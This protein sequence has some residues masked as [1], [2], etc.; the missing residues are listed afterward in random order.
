MLK[1]ICT[2]LAVILVAIL[3]TFFTSAPVLAADLRSGDTVTVASGD[4]VDDDLYIAGGSIVIDGTI[5]GDLWAV[6]RDVTVNGTVNGSLVAVA[7]TVDVNGQVGHAVRVAGETLHIRGD[8]GGDL[9]AFGGTLNVASTAVIGGDL[10]LGVGNARIDGLI[11][12]DVKGGGGEVT[13]AG[14]VQGDVELQV[15][16]L[17]VAPTANIQGDL[18]YT[19]KN[20]ADIESGAQVV[21]ATTHNVPEVEEAAEAATAV[22]I[23]GAVMGKVVAFLMILV[24]GI[25]TVLVAPRRLVSVADSIR[26]RPL[27]SLGWGAVVV[28]AAPIAAIVVCFTVIGIPVGLIV[29]ALWGIAIYLSQIPVALLIG[30]LITRRSGEMQSKGLLVG[31]LALGLVILVVL[32]A[33]PFLGFW[34]GLATALFGLGAVVVSETRLRAQG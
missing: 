13:I 10:L 28:F 4:V 24:I 17:T 15:D 23:A 5:N 26:T 22:A 34:V 8:V 21:G 12:G 7:Q 31:A 1:R 29:L 19:S 18:T 11:E 3:M 33:I 6:G 2:G 27:P 14:G 25:I 16:N 20:E 32:R 30:L 9:I